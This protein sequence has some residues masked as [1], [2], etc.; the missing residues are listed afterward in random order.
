[1]ENYFI[2]RNLKTIEKIRLKQRNLPVCC[3]D[4]LLGIENSTSSL[5]RLGYCYDMETFF[6]YLSA[7]CPK[8]YGKKLTEY[9]YDDL[10]EI[11]DSDL[12]HYLS[13]LNVYK[14][15]GGKIC[16]NSEK[17]KAR[18]FACIRAMFKFFFRKGK[19]LSNVTEKVTPPK[20]HEKEIVRLEVDEVAN[21]LD[22]VERGDKLTKQQQYFHKITEKR[23]VAILTLFLGTGIRI[24]E[25][26]GINIEDIDLEQNA[27]T[28]TRKGGNRVILY[29]SEEVKT[30]LVNY[31]NERLE[32]KNVDENER[33]L[34]IS[35][36]NRRMNVRTIELL[37]KKYSQLVT[38]L[39]HITPHKLR[40]TY[41]TNLYKET[42]DI[43]VVADVLGHRDVNTTKKYYAAITDD[44][45]RNAATKVK[46]R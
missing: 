44:I 37:V 45:R 12:E 8:F 5:T 30:A 13:Y 46:L 17:T 31:L 6:A 16:S 27:F 15:K 25:L 2:E 19:I 34:F 20:T 11:T 39:K 26:V 36:K 42:G 24:S 3:N 22:M 29:Y 32:N 23:D 14:N 1:M 33:A 38:P 21:L 18:K 43:Y 40:S 10:N 9:T 41:G 35:L 28:I 4:F 7:E